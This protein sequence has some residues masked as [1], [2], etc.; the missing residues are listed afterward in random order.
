MGRRWRRTEDDDGEGGDVGEAEHDDSGIAL[1]G[2][3][4]RAGVVVDGLGITAEQV[5][6]ARHGA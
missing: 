1:A 5:A 2:L 3:A 6:E 4:L